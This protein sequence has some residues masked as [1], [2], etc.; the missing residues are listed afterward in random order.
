MTGL[1]R[2]PTFSLKTAK[3]LIDEV[4]KQTGDVVQLQKL[5]HDEKRFWESLKTSWK[6]AGEVGRLKKDLS[7]AIE[8]ANKAATADPRVH[9][10][11]GTT[12]ETVIAQAQFQNGLIEFRLG[13]WEEALEC[14]ENSQK[15]MPTQEALFNIALCQL[16]LV[17]K[18]TFDPFGP[19]K[20]LGKKGKLF[21]PIW[22]KGA[23]KETLEAQ[24]RFLMA[25]S[26]S[27][28]DIMASF[29][30]VIDM[31]PE[32]DLAIEAGKIVARLSRR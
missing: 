5:A 11:D 20:D 12:P 4:S 15:T 30:R 31:N 9:L 18:V 25:G 7:L 32:T 27:L 2:T 28:D 29:N 16:N 3:G 21:R 17:K 13:K 22:E 1:T 6:A 8:L 23:V 14:F 19:F 24:K 26:Y 10:D